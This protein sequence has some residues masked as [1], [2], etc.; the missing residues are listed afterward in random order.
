MTLDEAY[1]KFIHL[2]ALLTDSTMIHDFQ[3]LILRD[4]W[5]AV[6]DDRQER[7]RRRSTPSPYRNAISEWGQIVFFPVFLL[8]YYR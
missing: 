1:D 7:K 5:Q 2:D 4:L 6:R 8:L 3:S